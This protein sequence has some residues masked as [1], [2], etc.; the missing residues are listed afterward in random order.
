MYLPALALAA[1]SGESS[2]TTAL[3]VVV[4]IALAILEIA[5]LWRIFTKAGERGWK[6]LIPIYNTIVLLR[7]VGRPWWW[8]LLMVIPFVGIVV[9]IVVLHD[10]SKAFGHGILFTLGLLLLP[11]IMMLVLAFGGSRYHGP[12]GWLK[13]VS[14]R[15]VELAAMSGWGSRGTSTRAEPG[16]S[17]QGGGAAAYDGNWARGVYSPGHGVGGAGSSP[18][19]SAGGSGSSPAYGG[20]QAGDAYGSG[21]PGSAAAGS[22]YSPGVSAARAPSMAPPSWHPDPR[23]RHELRYWDGTEWTDHVADAGTQGTDPV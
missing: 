22:G 21:S 16:N 20:Y 11:G 18:P 6:S 14:P 13:S 12:G 7:I 19:F 5:A 4:S 3:L 2:G 8:L 23:G 1:V 15:A 9:A 10:L 17:G